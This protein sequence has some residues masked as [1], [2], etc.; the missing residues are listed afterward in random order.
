MGLIDEIHELF[1]AA[2]DED[3]WALAK[4]L[5]REASEPR[6]Q[7]GKEIQWFSILTNLRS[8]RDVQS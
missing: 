7:Q 4:L 6:T 8:V 5:A 1:L 2:S 3:C